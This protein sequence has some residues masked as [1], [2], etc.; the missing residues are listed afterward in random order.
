[1]TASL[2]WRF[3]TAL[4]AL[5][6]IAGCYESSTRAQ[7]GT[8]T[9]DWF[10]EGRTPAGQTTIMT[11]PDGRITSHSFVHWNNR[12]WTTDVE[13]QLDEDGLVVSQRITGTSPFGAPIN[14]AFHNQGGVATWST[15]GERGTATVE[16]P[17]FY[18]PSELL[19]AETSAALI[20][21]ASK[22]PGQEIA[23]LPSGRARVERLVDRKVS[24]N[25]RDERAHL[26]AIIGRALTPGYLWL[27][28]DMNVVA[29]DYRGTMGMVPEGAGGSLLEELGGIQAEQDALFNER[30][31]AQLSRKLESPL[32]FEN[33][34]VAD[35]VDGKLL[36]GHYV[37]IE[38][39]KIALVSPDPIERADAIRVDGSGQA[40]IPGLWDMHGH[41]SLADGILNI[42]GGITS[43]R[44]IGGVHERVLQ[45]TDLFDRGV[46]IGPNTYRAGFIDK[47]GPYATGWPVQTLAEALDRV[48]FYAEHGYIQIKLYSSIE[49]DWVGPIAAR[50]RSHGLRVSG[51]VPAFMS[52]EQAVKAG[53][54]EIQH[55]NMV[56]LNFLAGDRED[57]RQQ[58]RFT[59]YGDEAGN[60]DLASEPVQRFLD[61][62][63]EHGVVVDATAAIFDAD[64]RH[65]PGDPNPLFAAVVDHLPPSEARRT[66]NPEMDI[67]DKVEARARSA[68]AQSAMLKAMHDRG[69]QLVPGSDGMAAFVLHRE[70]ETY[71]EAGITNADVLRIATLDSARV[72]GVAASKGSIEMGKDADL[73][74]LDANPFEDIRAIRRATFV[75]KGDTYYHP[76]ELFAA[77]GVT[78]FVKST[79]ASGAR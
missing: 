12:E 52:A 77:V 16:Q 38:H 59:L 79:P 45:A 37:L 7:N 63:A 41:F 54:D 24:I 15:L 6:F 68:A 66:Y 8:R 27:D 2:P 73:V 50:A 65:L 1:M 67:S 36:E 25:G 14:E 17:T 60:L 19:T 39:G 13:L 57:T 69:I 18:S 56:F 72:A 40:L 62:L 55:I 28:D 76:D 44:D 5:S 34:G 49:P 51:H 31:A 29:L 23:L 78:P 9:F 61:L 70:L 48:D 4:V 11:M 75:V 3:I 20:R 47:A 30:L 74:L 64:L 71:A 10:M 22:R 46:V 26:W 21:A 53:Y 43:V 58:I 42:A 35:V 33:V 32:I